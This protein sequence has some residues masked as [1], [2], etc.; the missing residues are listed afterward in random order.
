M[1]ECVQEELQRLKDPILRRLDIN[2]GI[3]TGTLIGGILGTK[4]VRYDIFG[5]DVYLTRFLEQHS[6]KGQVVVSEN[7]HNLI[8]KKAFIYDTFDW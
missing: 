5:K 8:K 4:L 7:T 2:V 3:H 6:V 1:V